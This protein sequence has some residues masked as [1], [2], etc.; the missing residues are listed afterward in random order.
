MKRLDGTAHFSSLAWISWTVAIVLV[1]STISPSFARAQTPFWPLVKISQNEGGLDHLVIADMDGDGD[2][3]AVVVDR[4]GDKITWRENVDGAGETWATREIARTSVMHIAVGDLDGDGDLDVASVTGILGD[5]TVW[6]HPDELG[7]PWPESSVLKDFKHPTNVLIADLDDDGHSDIVVTAE[8]TDKVAWFDNELGDGASFTARQISNTVA[9]AAAP[10][11]ADIDSDGDLDLVVVAREND[12]LI[13]LENVD[14]AG[15]AW[16]KYAVTVDMPF[17]FDAAVGDVDGDGD[18]DVIGSSWVRDNVTW[19]ENEAPREFW[20]EHPIDL[21]ILAAGAPEVGD[22]DGDGTLDLGAVE[23]HNDDIRWYANRLGDGTEWTWN[24]VV[25]RS[26][27]THSIPADM[28]GDGD[29]DLVTLTGFG[30]EWWRNSPLTWTVG[31]CP[32]SIT[33]HTAL[34]EPTESVAIAFADTE[35]AS[36]IPDGQL[37]AGTALDLDTPRLATVFTSDGS[38][39]SSMTRAFSDERCGTFF[40]A[41][42]LESCEVSGTAEVIPAD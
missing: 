29:L 1:L 33:I 37:C 13:W 26:G 6:S 42:D 14:G 10:H 12:A 11:A 31:Q 39:N 20:E 3:D 40:Q 24:S 27:A 7:T 9:G 28:D 18:I 36:Q 41:I 4:A 22:F 16:E 32:G 30:I 5:I 17:A 35:G 25:Q 19:W 23:S 21:D 38:G 15:T 2:L 8:S 34:T